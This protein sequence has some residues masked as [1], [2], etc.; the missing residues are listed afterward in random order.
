MP[1]GGSKPNFI[2]CWID[3]RVHGS[4]A[5]DSISLY[6]H[7]HYELDGNWHWN[8]YMYYCGVLLSVS[9]TQTRKKGLELKQKVVNEVSKN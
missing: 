4:N 7:I 6:V 5:L 8:N 2:L 1:L 3:Q 9:L